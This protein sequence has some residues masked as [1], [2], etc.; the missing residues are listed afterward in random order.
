MNY[1][2]AAPS[3]LGYYY[4]GCYALVTLLDCD[5]DCASVSTETRD[6]IEQITNGITFLKQLKHKPGTLYPVSLKSD[7]IWKTLRI[8]SQFVDEP[9]FYF[10]FITTKSIKSGDSLTYLIRPEPSVPLSENIVKTVAE[11]FAFEA[12]RVRNLRESAKKKGKKIPYKNRWPGCEAYL[13]LNESSRMNF[14]RRIYIMPEQFLAADI[15]VEV[16]KRLKLVHHTIRYKVAERL[17]EWWDREIAKALLEL[18]QRNIS[19]YEL[20]AKIT[21]LV[22]LIYEDQF[23]D[24]FR[25]IYAPEGLRAPLN[26]SRQIKWVGGGEEWIIRATKAR[27]KAQ[28]QRDKWI[29]DGMVAIQKLELFDED[30]K[31]EWRDRFDDNQVACRAGGKRNCEAGLELLKWSW[32]EAPKDVPP[33]QPDWR[34]PYLIRG[35]YQEMSNR[36]LVGWHPKFETLKEADHNNDS[37]ESD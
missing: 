15:Q 34:S 1:Q 7:D 22:T 23:V 12:N 33:I 2:S 35:T 29:S 13:M 31:E 32:Y 27:W 20:R 11:D 3:A 6:D 14:V 17:I 16:E 37:K 30:L 10:H 5:D 19:N 4:Q 21:E 25:S 26:M 8:W 36:F 28:Q 18:R 24:D 9:D